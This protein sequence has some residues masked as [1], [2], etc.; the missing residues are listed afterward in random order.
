MSHFHNTFT[1]KSLLMPGE[2]VTEAQAAE[3]MKTL[4]VERRVASMSRR[5]FFNK[6]AA[7]GAAAGA[8]A[9]AGCND[10]TVISPPG[11]PTAAP[12][13]TD[14]LNFALNLEYLEA[15]FYAYVTTG[16]G[17]PAADMGTPTGATTG[18]A[19]VAFV[20]PMVASIATQLATD[21]RLH[22]E[23]LRTQIVALGGTPVSMPA[24]NLAAGGAVTNDM[25]FLAA[26]RQLETVGISAYAGGAQYLV[27][28]TVALQYAA[29]ILD[30]EAQ[31]EGFLREL[32]IQLN[33][34]S[35]QVDSQDLPPTST[36][37]FNTSPTTGFNAVRTTSQ[38]LQIA[39]GAVG[40]T[41]VTSGGFFPAGMN[42]NIKST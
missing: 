39:Y 15:Q 2:T 21:E 30:T 37:I 10:A 12:S 13:V 16:S 11:T 8:L 25:T 1:Q 3:E 14:V 40:K 19:I 5:N 31:H 38:V 35:P 32:C 26:A 17:I 6:V 24:I 27:T 29:Q 23:L 4:T 18:G 9:L 33:V 41:G 28:S 36:Q 7:G 42:G 20:N 34:T 22:V